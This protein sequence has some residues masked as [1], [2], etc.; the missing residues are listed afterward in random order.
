MTDAPDE[1][2]RQQALLH[3]ATKGEKLDGQFGL[4]T[5][6]RSWILDTSFRDLYLPAWTTLHTQTSSHN[7]QKLTR[8]PH[9]VYAVTQ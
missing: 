9:T 6:R 5:T 7:S 4:D 1:D 8:N 2:A 3:W